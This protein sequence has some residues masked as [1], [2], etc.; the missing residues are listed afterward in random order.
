MAGRGLHIPA[1]ELVHRPAVCAGGLA[2]RLRLLPAL[3]TRRGHG[4]TLVRTHRLGS[5][6]STRGGGGALLT[7]AWHSF[8]ERPVLGSAGTIDLVGNVIFSIAAVALLVAASRTVGRGL[9]E[10]SA[11]VPDE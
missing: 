6:P 11:A 8:P 3:W 4:R 9:R 5:R 7:Y 10:A 2:A 1:G